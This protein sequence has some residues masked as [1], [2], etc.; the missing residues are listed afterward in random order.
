MNLKQ[1]ILSIIHIKSIGDAAIGALVAFLGGVAGYFKLIYFDNADMFQAIA[2]VVFVDFFAGVAVAI[3][4]H[5]FETHKAMK[6]IYYL[7]IYWALLAMVLQV[8]KGFPSAFW[9][10]EAIIMPILVFQVISIL[11]NLGL[12]GIIQNQLL[13]D[14]LSKIDKHKDSTANETN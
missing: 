6:V 9:L 5:K 8:E 14:I 13:T 11:K 10:S 2:W 12:L 3:K 4:M 1:T 7:A